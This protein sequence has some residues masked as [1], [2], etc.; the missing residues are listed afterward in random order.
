M[1]YAWLIDV[2]EKRGSA[3]WMLSSFESQSFTLCS[4]FPAIFRTHMHGVNANTYILIQRHVHIVCSS[5]LHC[6]VFYCLIS[7]R[8]NTGG[9]P[10]KAA[11][12]ADCTVEPLFSAISRCIPWFLSFCFHIFIPCC[13]DWTPFCQVLPAFVLF[14]C[15][16]FLL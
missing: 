1:K 11:D 2:K 8:T 5:I 4:W 16:F 3:I 15:F 13:R 9:R 6:D 12:S 10:N 7:K 14:L